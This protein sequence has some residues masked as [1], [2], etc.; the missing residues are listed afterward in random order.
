MELQD[1]KLCIHTLQ[2]NGDLII[3]GMNLNDPIQRHDHTEI[4]LDGIYL[5]EAIISKHTGRNP[6]IKTSINESY[7]P[8]DGM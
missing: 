3:L 7:Y 5:Y 1:L 8:I 2:E 6:L 4:V